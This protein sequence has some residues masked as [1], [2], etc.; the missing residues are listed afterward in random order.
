MT[1][2]QYE[3]K[4]RMKL[5]KLLNA[6]R[7]IKSYLFSTNRYDRYDCTSTGT[8]GEL[9]IF[10]IK[11]RQIPSDKYD[12]ILLE[13][14]K[15]D[16]MVKAYQDSGYTPYYINFY[17]DCYYVFPLLKIENVESRTQEI[18]ATP[19]TYN[20]SYTDKVVKKVIMLNKEE[21]IRCQYE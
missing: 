3:E 5:E 17:T 1:T 16:A 20:Y 8:S 10:E 21:G 6:S 9:T 14:G 12:T 4:G 13:R 11:D 19:N 15:Y 2:K 18:P 7:K